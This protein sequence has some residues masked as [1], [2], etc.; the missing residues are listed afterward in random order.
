MM[1]TFGV[2]A[3]FGAGLAATGPPWPSGRKVRLLVAVTG[4]EVCLVAASPWIGLLYVG[5]AVAGLLSIWYISLANALV[6]LRTARNLQGRVMGVWTMALPGMAPVTS[7]LIGAV[8]AWGAGADGAREA[9][10]LAG[11]ALLIS[12][13]LGWRALADNEQS[14]VGIGAIRPAEVGAS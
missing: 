9:F 13:A 11:V 8:A 1:A 3:L 4:A 10:G 5:L 6:Q 14:V 2:G 7:L 12:A